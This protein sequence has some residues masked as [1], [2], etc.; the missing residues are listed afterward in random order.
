MLE[1]F[2]IG[3][4]HLCLGPKSELHKLYYR[5]HK[6]LSLEDFYIFQLAL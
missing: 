5:A 2:L 6:K 1:I 3:L 4:R